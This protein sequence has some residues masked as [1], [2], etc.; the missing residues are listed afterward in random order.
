VAVET[1][2]AAIIARELGIPA[3]VGSVNATELLQ[4]GDMVTVCC[5]EG[6]TGLV[7][8]GALV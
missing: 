8:Q 5:S 1:C 6:E 7:F 2:H 3:I 4:D